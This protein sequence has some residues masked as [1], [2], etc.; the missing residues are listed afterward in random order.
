MILYQD[1]P[2]NL[3]MVILNNV[4]FKSFGIGWVLGGLAILA[5]CYTTAL[6]AFI[7]YKPLYRFMTCT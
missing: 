4:I 5:A 6:N 2:E 3:V 1:N 7:I